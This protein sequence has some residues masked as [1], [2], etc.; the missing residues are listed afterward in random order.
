MTDIRDAVRTARDPKAVLDAECDRLNALTK[1]GV[2]EMLLS[3]VAAYEAKTHT[4]REMY[5][6]LRPWWNRWGRAERGKA[7]NEAAKRLGM[8]F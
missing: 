8:V 3:C 2:D 6:R 4:P 5:A 1:E 7:I